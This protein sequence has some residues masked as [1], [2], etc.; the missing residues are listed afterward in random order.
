MKVAKLVSCSLITRVI[1]DENSTN[2]EI[3]RNSKH[4]FINIINDSLGDNI[5]LI[6][7][8]EEC[9]YEEGEEYNIF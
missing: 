8:D 5:E 6:E 3:I 9:P 4:H 1:V 7:D 2:D